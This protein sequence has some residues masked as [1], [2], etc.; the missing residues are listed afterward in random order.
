[1][2]FQLAQD[3]ADAIDAM[4]AAHPRRKILSLLN[5]AIRRD[6]H[7]I[8]RHPTTMFQCMWNT[9]WWYDC[10]EAANHYSD[11][12]T[13]SI[14]RARG[15]FQRLE[16][17]KVAKEECFP[18]A[19]WLRAVRPPPESMGTVLLSTLVG[20][21]KGVKSLAWFPDGIRLVSGGLDGKI[22]IWDSRTNRCLLD[23]SSDGEGVWCVACSRDGQVVASGD[24]AGMISLWDAASGQRMRRF[25]AHIGGVRAIDF[26]PIK[27]CFAS[28]GRDNRL[29][30][31]DCESAE[32]VRSH[33]EFI[34]NC[35]KYSPDGR[36][37]ATGTGMKA[38][39]RDAA[40]GE[41]LRSIRKKI[42]VVNS[43]G[44]SHDGRRIAIGHYDVDILDLAAGRET[45]VYSGARGV[46][47]VAFSP[48][49]KTLVIGSLQEGLILCDTDSGSRLRLLSPATYSGGDV[50]SVAYAPNDA[51]I[52]S[53]SIDGK[54]RLWN[55]DGQP[56]RHPRENR[57]YLSCAT[58][59]PDDKY[60][61]TG[62]DNGVVTSWNAKTGQ[63]AW[64][65]GLSFR[66]ITNL[67][68]TNNRTTLAVKAHPTSN[69]E[70]RPADWE[71]HIWDSRQ[72][73]KLWMIPC[74][75]AAQERSPDSRRRFSI[76]GNE[77]HLFRSG[78]SN[79]D[80][81]LAGH[82]AKISC[83][84]WTLDSCT[85]VTGATD[86]EIRIWDADSGME[87]GCM[88]GNGD[89]I[90]KLLP[91]PDD[92]RVVFGAIDGSI[93]MLDLTLGAPVHRLDGQFGPHPPIV[94]S[95]DGRRILAGLQNGMIR[96]WATD[97]KVEL[98][99]NIQTDLSPIARVT[100]DPTGRYILACTEDTIG[101]WHAE[102]GE[103]LEVLVPVMGLA[104]NVSQY[105]Q[106]NAELTQVD[107][108]G[109]RLAGISGSHLYIISVEQ[110]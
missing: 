104:P 36:C 78:Q 14:S 103:V 53:G 66:K 80:H 82:D 31:W 17:W 89:S 23:F 29:R 59:S 24:S 90:S 50:Y 108:S 70:D 75:D 99:L 88:P 38:R 100:F 9:C 62:S 10:P 13:A 44:Y 12:D 58:F 56:V 6:I 64:R 18:G 21:T 94:C 110:S 102:S 4:P 85:V 16:L 71:L 1:M 37:I 32:E 8:D 54:I 83:C 46:W 98:L 91:L 5:E 92:K 96:I 30:I 52:A 63:V 20:H 49:G 106:F 34:P 76:H 93:R 33:E 55:T 72:G 68:F 105:P 3:F 79:P 101:I 60:V 15:L 67:W 41:I 47:S 86:G 107:S 57:Y 22:F 69:F 39:V 84:S 43:L 73:E 11:V 45:S 26:S 109:Q 51:R 27:D 28:V 65:D 87:R 48:D 74:T 95:A 25:N 97:K 7:F 61:L 19:A 35:V 77:L 40:S 42:Y 81:V 2:I